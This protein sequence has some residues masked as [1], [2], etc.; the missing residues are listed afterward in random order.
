MLIGEI[1][2]YFYMQNSAYFLLYVVFKRT[3]V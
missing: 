3:S 2:N 1:L